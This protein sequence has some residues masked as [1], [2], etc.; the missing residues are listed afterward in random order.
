M[1]DADRDGSRAQGLRRDRLAPAADRRTPQYRIGEPCAVDRAVARIGDGV[2][3]HRA[4][5]HGLTDG[6]AEPQGTGHAL[7]PGAGG[8]P[9]THAERGNLRAGAHGGGVPPGRGADARGTGDC[10]QPAHPEALAAWAAQRVPRHGR[11][12]ER[13]TVQIGTRAVGQPVP[14]DDGVTYPNPDALRLPY[15]LLV[16]GHREDECVRPH[17]IGGGLRGPG[18]QRPAARVGRQEQRSCGKQTGSGAGDGSDRH[19]GGFPSGPRMCR[20][21][22]S[23]RQRHGAGKPGARRLSCPCGEYTGWRTL[24]TPRRA[25]A[26]YAFGATVAT[27]ACPSP[28]QEVGVRRG[29]PPRPLAGEASRC[30]L[31]RALRV[32]SAGDQYSRHAEDVKAC[33][34][35]GVSVLGQHGLVRATTSPTPPGLT[36]RPSADPSWGRRSS[37]MRR[38]A[39]SRCWYGV[40]ATDCGWPSRPTRTPPASRPA[41]LT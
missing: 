22:V 40:S 41:R 26:S 15:G 2:P 37:S 10:G 31:T 18:G 4:R 16:D 9:G 8:G 24:D 11:V 5:R 19:P 27:D 6:D 38:T 34:R 21:A 1:R 12:G 17:P 35:S 3:H 20:T 36:R 23:V 25:R 13:D 7:I 14:L 33:R 28:N 39:R 30:S 29:Q 32:C